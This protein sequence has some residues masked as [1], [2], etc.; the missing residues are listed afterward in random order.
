MSLL[1]FLLAVY[2]L[3]GGLRVDTGDGEVVYQVTR[4]I[5]QTGSFAIPAPAE[6]QSLFGSW[7]RDGR[8]YGPYG[9][10]ASLS[11]LPFYGLGAFV[12]R[13]TGWATHGY[14]TRAAVALRNIV[15]GALT[16]WAVLLLARRLEYST[17]A[18][19]FA[20]LASVLATPFVVYVKTTFSEPLVSLMLVLALAAVVE[21]PADVPVC[22]R[23]RSSAWRWLAAGGLLGFGFLVKPT[24][25]AVAPA[26]VGYALWS[27]RASS[28]WWALGALAG[29]LVVSIGLTGWYNAVRFGSPLQ[30]GY[31]GIHFRLAPWV[32]LYGL[33]L[34]PGKG[35]LLFCPLVVLGMLGWR[36][37]AVRWPGP[38]WL[39]AACAALYVGEHA[40]YSQWT[41]GGGWGPR[42]IVPII[43]LLVVPLGEW[44]GNESGARARELAAALLVALSLVIQLPAVAVH[45]G[46]SAQAVYAESASEEEYKDRI[47]YRL[48]DSALWRQWVGLL[49]VSTLM[50]RPELR[51]QVVQTAR[52]VG[53]REA[54]WP[55]SIASD[56][57]VLTRTVGLLAFNTFDFWWVYWPLLGAPLWAVGLAVAVLLAVAVVCGRSLDRVLRAR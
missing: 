54:A 28:R 29:P 42:L 7:G 12:H 46:R 34:S 57:D 20:A 17:R 15:A 13:A 48:A 41:G 22:R 21:P 11:L 9:L 4:S 1:G 35:L 27:Q 18:A 50:R 39:I 10:G 32:G 24:V 6:G 40:I 19:V 33:L 52:Q 2:A 5:A 44:K 14:V 53:L 23:H 37:L 51:A 56:A 49:E 3:I 8:F 26:F 47:R 43:P 30:T 38:A 25:I 31:W 45:W 16:G 55:L 36:R